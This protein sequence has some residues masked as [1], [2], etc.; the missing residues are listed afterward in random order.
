[1]IDTESAEEVMMDQSPV[2]SLVD[3]ARDGDQDAWNGLVDRFLPLVWSV[4]RVN[5]LTGADAEDVN[6]TVWLRLV[7][8][9]DQIRDS[10]ALPGWI[11]TTTRHECWRVSR[12]RARVVPVDPLEPYPQDPRPEPDAVE[13][14]L[15]LQERH[16]ALREAL[17]ELPAGRRDLLILLLQDPPLSYAE[18]GESLGLPVGSI[19]P[20]RGR[21]LA[22]LRN[23]SAFRSLI[24]RYPAQ[25][26]R[27]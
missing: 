26:R 25:P 20:T 2:A 23:T 15:L 3:R 24:A 21:A 5:G 13:D 18:I 17:A 4:I 27:R 9:L 1:M 7:E 12:I 14:D 6:Q 16:R 19:G 8:H 10:N 22:Q 11:Q